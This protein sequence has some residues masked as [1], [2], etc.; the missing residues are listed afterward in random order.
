MEKQHPVQL[1][2]EVHDKLKQYSKKTGL[3]IKY[4]VE[5]AIISYLNTIRFQEMIDNTMEKNNG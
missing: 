5:A 4:I 1:E 2:K 3:K